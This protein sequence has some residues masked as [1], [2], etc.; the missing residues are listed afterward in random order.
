MNEDGLNLYITWLVIAIA[1]LNPSLRKGTENSLSKNWFRLKI[2]HSEHI[3]CKF[4]PKER[5]WAYTQKI[6]QNDTL[7]YL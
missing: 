3:I 4:E 5:E 2:K 1:E 7:D 6:Y